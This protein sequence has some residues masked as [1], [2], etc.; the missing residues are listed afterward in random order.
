MRRIAA[1]A[2]VLALVLATVVAQVNSWRS[3]GDGSWVQASAIVRLGP[4]VYLHTNAAHAAVGIAAIEINAYG[5]VVITRDVPAGTKIAA[6]IA[7]EDE[8]MVAL[9][10][11]A[12]CSGGSITSTIRMYDRDGHRVRADDPRF[13]SYSNLWL[14]WTGFQPSTGGAS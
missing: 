14:Y 7:E 6:C 10:I 4:E 9:G 11:Q 8:S 12:G 2:A 5:D 13:G 1:A 3:E